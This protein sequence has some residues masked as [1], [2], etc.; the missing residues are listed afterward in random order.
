MFILVEPSWTLIKK[1]KVIRSETQKS[2]TVSQCQS[3]KERDMGGKK[4]FLSLLL[5]L[6]WKVALTEVKSDK[7]C[8]IFP[9]SEKVFENKIKEIIQSTKTSRAPNMIRP[10]RTFAAISG[11]PSGHSEQ[12]AGSQK[13][14]GN[15]IKKV[16]FHQCYSNPV[17]CF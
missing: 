14:R 10:Q 6:C 11:N 4:Y 15:F 1:C 9:K 12:L 7:I 8:F 13:R 2:V 16:M 3:R 5:F 17:S